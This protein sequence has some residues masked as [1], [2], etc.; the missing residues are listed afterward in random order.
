MKI[1][2][3]KGFT[4]IEVIVVA[5]IIAILAGILVPLIFKEIDEA[6]L[7]RAAADVRSIYAAMLVFKKDTANWPSMDA[8]CADNVTLLVGK[9]S[10]PTN[11]AAM[12]YVTTTTSSYLDHLVA[13]TNGCYNNW[14]GPYIADVTADPWGNAY[15]TNA[16]GFKIIGREVWIISAGPNGVMDTPVPNL[17]GAQIVGDDIGLRVK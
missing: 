6:R 17:A 9:G 16:D 12:G 8:T 11:L 2:G 1:R 13:D 3:E 14:K 5:G 15:L 10:F 4:L 7:S